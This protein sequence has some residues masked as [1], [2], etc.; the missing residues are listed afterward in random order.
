M[1][2]SRPAS[3]DQAIRR[4]ELV[5]WSILYT[6]GVFVITLITYLIAL[7]GFTHVVAGSAE[8]LYLWLAAMEAWRAWRPEM[9]LTAGAL[10]FAVL[11]YAQVREEIDEL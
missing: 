2:R 1:G 8:A 6:C 7:G 9:L 4:R 10:M 5:F 11:S 3:A